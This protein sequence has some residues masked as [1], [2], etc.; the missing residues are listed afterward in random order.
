MSQWRSRKR[1]TRS[2]QPIDPDE[3]KFLFLLGDAAATEKLAMSIPANYSVA[4]VGKRSEETYRFNDTPIVR[5]LM[6]IHDH[7]EGL[8]IS[9]EERF[10]RSASVHVRISAMVEW[11]EAAKTRDPATENLVWVADDKGEPTISDA[12]L[13]AAARAEMNTLGHFNFHKFLALVEHLYEGHVGAS[14]FMT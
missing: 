11:I 9:E 4:I 5:A 1:Q 10:S 12:V 14:D 13:H 6:A 8:D 2:Y 3:F 7:Y